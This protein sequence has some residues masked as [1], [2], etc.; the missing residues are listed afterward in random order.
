VAKKTNM[1]LRIK[2]NS[3]RIRLTKTEVNEL[4]ESGYLQEETIFPNNRFVYAL[5][6]ADDAALSAIFENN[7]I[8]MLVPASF[9]KDWPA[10]NMVGLENNMQLPNKE[11]L[12]LLI[13]KDFVCLDDTTEDQSDNYEN[14]NKTC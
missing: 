9:I 3:L 12:F 2:G 1:K 5:Q 10:N 13:E 8:T 11:S 7:K 14:P 6:K 4:A